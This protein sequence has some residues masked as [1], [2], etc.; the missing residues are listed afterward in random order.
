MKNTEFN[1]NAWQA[2]FIKDCI[3]TSLQTFLPSFLTELESYKQKCSEKDLKRWQKQLNQLPPLDNVSLDIDKHVSVRSTKVLDDSE[4]KRITA[5]LKNFMPWRKGPFNFC[6]INIDTE[7]RSDWKWDRVAPHIGDLSNQRILDVGCGSGYH[8]FR[9]HKSGAKQVIGIDP[10]ALFFYQ[11][12]CFKQYLP[13]LNIHFLPIG[14]EKM[15][16]TKA[17][18][19]VF[20]MGVFYHR[21]DP[22]NFLKELKD[23]ISSTG[24]LVLETLVIEGD[25]NTTLMPKDRYAQMRNVWFIPSVA[26][27]VVMLERVGFKN[28][29]CVDE[30]V[31]SLDEQRATAWMDNHSL[32]D[33]LDPDDHS[34]TIEGYQAPKRAVMIADV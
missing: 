32:V 2:A 30:D 34:K 6:S 20:S 31:T 18:D 15:P 14:I 28:I 21:P 11:F 25:E 12:H 3:G 33:F 1:D 19:T 10:T 13:T 9:M 26:A 22:I 24:Q 8:L 17:F 7:W 16:A 27:L 5:V 4:Q 29:R 23:Q